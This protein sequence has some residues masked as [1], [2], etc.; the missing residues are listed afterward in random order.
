[1]TKRFKNWIMPKIKHN[2]LTKWNWTV[3]YPENFILGYNTDIGS[4]TYIQAQYGVTIEKDVEIGSH[5][6]IYSRSTIDDKKGM[7]LICEKAKVGSHSIIMP[8]VIIGK[9]VI[10]GAHSFVNK[11]IPPC[12]VWAGI[13]AR[14]ILEVK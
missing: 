9:N 1:M 3:S 8:G 14:K 2:K 13:P 11:T 10:I 4:F 6:S 5:C 7:V 12:E